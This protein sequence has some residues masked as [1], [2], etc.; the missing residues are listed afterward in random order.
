MNRTYFFQARLYTYKVQF[1]VSNAIP[2]EDK[3]KTAISFIT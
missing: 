3:Y 2:A 1:T